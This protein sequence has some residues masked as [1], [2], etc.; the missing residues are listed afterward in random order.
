M[1]EPYED[2]SITVPVG[3]VM[4]FGEAKAF[5]MMVTGC[6]GG[7]KLELHVDGTV[8]GDTDAFLAALNDMTQLQAGFAGVQIWAIARAIHQDRKP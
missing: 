2:Y 7:W 6:G 1:S 4:S 8:T 5:P 3:S